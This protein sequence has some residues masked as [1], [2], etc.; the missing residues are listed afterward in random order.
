MRGDFKVTTNPEKAPAVDF[1]TRSGEG[2]FID[3][4]VDVLLR[5]QPGMPVQTERVY[6]AKNTVLQLA[7]MLG[8][9]GGSAPH[10]PARDG[11]LI[12]QGKI[13]AMKENLGGN[14]GDVVRTLGRVLDALDGGS[15][16]PGGASAL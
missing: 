11:A 8:I 15:D 3:T 6:I 16:R 1:L 5:S 4:G 9:T 7:Q 10:D 12:A 14:L 2:P 13:E